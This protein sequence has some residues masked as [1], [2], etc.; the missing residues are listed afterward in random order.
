[1]VGSAPFRGD[2]ALDIKLYH[3]YIKTLPDTE[4]AAEEVTQ[5]MGVPS[6][7]DNAHHDVGRQ[8]RR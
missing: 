3:C 4:K 8:D 1:M 6:P 2:S 5:H 7:V